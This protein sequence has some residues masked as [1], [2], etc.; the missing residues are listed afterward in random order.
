MR[1]EN[2]VQPI[3]DSWTSIQNIFTALDDIKIEKVQ[4]FAENSREENKFDEVIIKKLSDAVITFDTRGIRDLMWLSM[5]I[6]HEDKANSSIQDVLLSFYIQN[7]LARP[8]VFKKYFQDKKWDKSKLDAEVEQYQLRVNLGCTSKT[9]A[10]KDIGYIVALFMLLFEVFCKSFLDE[11]QD[12]LKGIVTEGKLKKAESKIASE[13]RKVLTNE[14]GKEHVVKGYIQFLKYLKRSDKEGNSKGGKVRSVANED[15][16]DYW[17]YASTKDE[18]PEKGYKTAVSRVVEFIDHAEKSSEIILSKNMESY[19][20]RQDIKLKK[21]EAEDNFNT[22]SIE[23]ITSY[24]SQNSD[25]SPWRDIDLRN[26]LNELKSVSRNEIKYLQKTESAWLNPF[27]EYRT[28]IPLLVLSTLRVVA[29]K[30][31]QNYIQAKIGTCSTEEEKNVILSDSFERSMNYIDQ[32]ARL[33]DIRE[34]LIQCKS[35]ALAILDQENSSLSDNH[36]RLIKT[37]EDRRKDYPG[38]K[39]GSKMMRSGFKLEDVPEA[40]ETRGYFYDEHIRSLESSSMIIEILDRYITWFDSVSLDFPRIFIEDTDKFRTQ[41]RK[42][43]LSK[44]N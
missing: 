42:I 16:F 34:K 28:K 35:S 30:P 4:F 18:H 7:T 19:D 6:V 39:I 36:R 44:D 40:L 11:I 27:F 14:F 2:N 26:P 15:I 20:I 23:H 25:E 12:M 8:E 24:N 17:I 31:A 32:K 1:V 22:D 33:V 29:F 5:L 37:M 9:I 13:L 41:F 38:L 3:G 43:Y 10:Y 21:Q